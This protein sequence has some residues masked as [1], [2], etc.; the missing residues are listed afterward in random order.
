MDHSVNQKH[1]KQEIVKREIRVEEI[2][3]QKNRSSH[4]E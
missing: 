1:K 3:E 2:K 4:V